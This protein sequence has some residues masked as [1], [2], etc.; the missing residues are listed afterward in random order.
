MGRMEEMSTD[1]YGPLKN[2]ERTKE[3]KAL[4]NYW[5][6]EEL[7]LLSIS[8]DLFVKIWPPA[9]GEESGAVE[10]FAAFLV[11]LITKQIY[12]LN[13]FSYNISQQTFLL[14]TELAVC[15]EDIQNGNL[16]KFNNSIY[17]TWYLQECHIQSTDSL[18][19]I[20]H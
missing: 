15:P 3:I 9:R 5:L 4:R 19:I 14:L 18:L 2:V 6:F 1:C 17:S 10:T 20:F 13:L 12:K 8:T 16:L 7:V 11:R